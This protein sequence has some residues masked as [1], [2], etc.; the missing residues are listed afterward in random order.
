MNDILLVSE[1]SVEFPVVVEFPVAFC[2]PKTI[3][4][5]I[6]SRDTSNKILTRRSRGPQFEEESPPAYG[7]VRNEHDAQL[8][9]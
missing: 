4:T 6:S 7:D 8:A 1:A 2:P 9:T 3:T 5:S